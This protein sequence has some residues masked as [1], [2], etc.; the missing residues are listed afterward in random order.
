MGQISN[1]LHVTTYLIFKSIPWVRHY[2]PI[3]LAKNYFLILYMKQNRCLYFT[4]FVMGE[5]HIKQNHKNKCMMFVKLIFESFLEEVMI[6][7]KTK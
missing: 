3:Y 5:T 1:V 7:A 6:E 2:T 4:Y